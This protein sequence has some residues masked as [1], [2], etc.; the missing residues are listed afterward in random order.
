MTATTGPQISNLLEKMLSADKDFRFM[1]CNDLITELQKD[2]I[3]LDD[4]IERRVSL[5]IHLKCTNIPHCSDHQIFVEIVGRQKW[6]STE[7]GR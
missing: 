1:A 2:S 4:D 6:R 7:F 5:V 3:K